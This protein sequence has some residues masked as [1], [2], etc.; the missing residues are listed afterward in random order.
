MLTL[1]RKAK[2]SVVIYHIDRPKELIEVFYGGRNDYGAAK[3][4]FSAHRDYQIYRR[5]LYDERQRDA[6]KEKSC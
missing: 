6:N 4:S 1:S 5:E 2:E 3:L